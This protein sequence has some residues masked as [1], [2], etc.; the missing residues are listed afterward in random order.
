MRKILCLGLSLVVATSI[1]CGCSPQNGAKDKN[2]S[3]SKSSNSGPEELENVVAEMDTY[4]KNSKTWGSVLVNVNGGNIYNKAFGDSDTNKPNETNT[5]Y[6]IG[7]ITKQFTGMA[8]LQLEAQGKM[9][10]D[11]T[12]DKYFDADTYDYISDIKVSELCNMTGGF[13]DYMV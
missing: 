7:S 1:F 9:S 4:L 3:Q 10:A 2:K 6:Q 13:G 8:I 11:D 5:I 12:L